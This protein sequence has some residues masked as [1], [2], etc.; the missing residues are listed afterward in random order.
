M[1]GKKLM[2]AA[3]VA[4]CLVSLNALA[5][6]DFSALDTAELMQLKP[7]EMGEE[8]RNAF[9]DEMRKHTANMSSTEKEEFRNQ[10]REQKKSQ[11]GWAGNAGKR[12][13]GAGAMTFSLTLMRTGNSR[14]HHDWTNTDSVST[15]T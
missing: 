6:Q 7:N 4:L 8:D 2:Q 13:H 15:E 9:R 1:Y 12:W 5:A 14:R 3:T 11:G 10:M